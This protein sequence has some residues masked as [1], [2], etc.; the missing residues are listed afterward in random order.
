M[1]SRALRKLQK[2]QEEEKLASLAAEDSENDAAYIQEPRKPAPKFN[3]FDLL[4]AAEEEEES[5]RG[6]SEEE[7]LQ[8]VEA[9]PAPPEPPAPSKPTESKKKKKKKKAKKSPA[10]AG[11]K[12]TGNE[13]AGLD[14]IDRALKE[15]STTS[16]SQHAGAQDDTEDAEDNEIMGA[17]ER[18][19]LLSVE[20]K[21]LNA[22][23]EMKKLFG[24]VVMET[25][26]ENQQD[27]APRRRR[28]RNRQGVDLGRALTGRY[29]PA[30]GGQ[31][32]SGI[33]TRKNVLMQGK[34]EWPR[35]TSGGLGMEVVE[36]RPSGVTSFKIVHNR[37][38]ND[39]QRQFDTCV[40]S[41]DP[42]R[43]IQLLQFNREFLPSPTA[44]PIYSYFSQHITFQHSYKSP[45]SQSSRETTQ[46]PPTSWNELCSILDGLLIL[47]SV[48]ALNKVELGWTSNIKKIGN[49]G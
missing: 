36:K 7:A 12:P 19:R 32:L 25:R 23:N 29:N 44:W 26:Q 42:Q 22:M 14:D 2:Q 46:F 35:A 41:M 4:N 6:E 3:A 27:T 15:L 18:V 28:D 11:N 33:A 39:V 16:A 10:A 47:R 49:Y 1:S 31:D 13:E 5:D 20:P 40:E 8:P 24:N 30:S 45:K 38:Y 48:P 17:E 9:P 37:A 34:D 21:N 43:L